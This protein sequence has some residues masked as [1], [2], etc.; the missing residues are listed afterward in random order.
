[1]RGPDPTAAIQASRAK[2]D[3]SFTKNAGAEYVGT[4]ELA[5]TFSIAITLEGDH[6]IEQAT[7]QAKLPMFAESE[8]MF[9]LKAVDAQIE[10][11]KNEKGEVTH[12]VLR[13]GGRNTKGTK[14]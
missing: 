3:H 11:F 1:L 6:L 13:Q 2:G 7:G 8:T 9:F 4:Y 5:P 14:K 12:L 10:F